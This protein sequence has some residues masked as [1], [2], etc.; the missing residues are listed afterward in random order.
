METSK[1]R[2]S[3]MP[4]EMLNAQK[5]VIESETMLLGL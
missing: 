5:S 4:M 1:A 3:A 2:G